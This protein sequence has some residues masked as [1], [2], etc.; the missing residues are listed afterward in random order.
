MKNKLIRRFA[1]TLA[2]VL[3]MAAFS[4]TAYAGGADPDPEPLPETTEAPLPEETEEPTTGGME[5][6]P[7]GVPVTPEGN[8]AL[9]DD[10]FGDKQLI[11]V[12]TKAGNYFYILIDRANEDKETSVHFLNQVDDA[13]LQALLEDGEQ[14]PQVCTCTAKCEAGAVNTACPVCKN[15]LTACA[16]PE[17]EPADAEEP[18]APEK[19][20]GGMG[21]LVVFLVVVLAGGGAALYFFKLRKPKAD[22]KG[23]DDLDEYDFGEDEDE[24]EAPEPDDATDGDTQEPGEDLLIEEE[25]TEMNKEDE[26]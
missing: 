23:S 5:M 10:F 16:G 20:S 4:V 25:A 7:E 17:P 2:A 6:E 21:G 9:V 22:V 13:D 14:E 24:E 19:E 15:N 8:A 18:T 1:V 12:T 3:C 26:E 11:T